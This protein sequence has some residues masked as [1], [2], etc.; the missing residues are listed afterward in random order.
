MWLLNLIN[1]ISG[2]VKELGNAYAAHENA[3]TDQERV[4]WRGR[5]RAL[6]LQLDAAKVAMAHR[7]FWIGWLAFVLP[8]SFYVGK[9]EVWD[10]AL[11][12]GRSDPLK[13]QVLT[14]ASLIISSMFASGAAVGIGSAVSQALSSV[15]GKR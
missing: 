8:L 10:A 6:E 14:W 13:G 7:A 1:P 12:F 4:Q 15:F 2:I 3:Q 11:G 9:I 5:I